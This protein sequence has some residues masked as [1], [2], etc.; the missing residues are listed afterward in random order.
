MGPVRTAMSFGLP[1]VGVVAVD[2]LL[3]FVGV[4]VVDVCPVGFDVLVG[5]ALEV[6]VGGSGGFFVAGFCGVAGDVE[7]ESYS[8]RSNNPIFF[9]GGRIRH[10]PTLPPI[11]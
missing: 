10:P 7:A 11:I 2:G 1:E 9:W 3:G 8:S 6:L 5:S 4:G